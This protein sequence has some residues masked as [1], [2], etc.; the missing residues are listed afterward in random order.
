MENNNRSSIISLVLVLIIAGVVALL[1]RPIWEEVS[2]LQ[3]GFND[4]QSQKVALESQLQTLRGAQADLEAKTEVN[5]IKTLDAIPQ[6]FE[7]DALITKLNQ[8][9]SQNTVVVNSVSFNVPVGSTEVIKKAQI[10]VNVTSDES[11]L[12][13]FLKDIEESDRKMTVK[14]ITVQFGQTDGKKRA[15]YTL[16]LE[17][18]YQ[19]RI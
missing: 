15:N 4:K 17:T 13:S 19:D 6:R 3:M 18:F 12:I 14:T 9:A 1:F 2:Q 8:I 16:S 5:K 7:Q 11:K 10:N